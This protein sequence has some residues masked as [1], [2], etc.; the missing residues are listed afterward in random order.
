MVWERSKTFT[1]NHDPRLPDEALPA[2]PSTK[3]RQD[4]ETVP[5]A[6]D[7]KA[8]FARDGE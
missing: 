8:R 4:S 1:L 7:A 3:S 2:D 5:R 6:W